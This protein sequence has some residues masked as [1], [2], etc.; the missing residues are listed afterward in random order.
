M[1]PPPALSGSAGERAAALLEKLEIFGIRPGLERTDQLLELLARPERAQPVVLVGG[2]NGKGSTATLL[3]AMVSA[4]GYRT[5]L[6]TSPHLESLNERIAI[7]G[8]KI[9][10]QELAEDLEHILALA[11]HHRLDPPTHFEILTLAA[12]LHF[13]RRQVDLAIMEVGLGGRLDATNASRPQLSILTSI[14]FDHEQYLGTSLEAIA[15]E[16]AA[17]FRPGRP[18]LAHGGDDRRRDLLRRLAQ[19]HQAELRLVEEQVEIEAH[20]APHELPQRLSARTGRGRYR[21][22]LPLAG[23][24]QRIHLALA[25]AAAEELAADGFA[26]LDAAAVEGGARSSRWPGRLERVELPGGRQVLL[27]AAHNAA[28]AAALARYLHHLGGKNSLVFGAL[29][30]KRIDEM[31]DQLA[32]CATEIILTRPSN[33]RAADPHRWRRTLGAKVRLEEEPRR[34]LAEALERTDGRIVICG[35]IY[36]VGELRQE[37]RALF[38]VPPP[39]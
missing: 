38:G 30:D 4:A 24:H 28:G 12:W 29:A 8:R 34:A 15:G 9:S 37:L 6:Y 25:V 27:D 36:L 7:D 19:Q 31:L 39:P 20:G 32:P 26:R 21:V 22:S 13:R 14:D 2:T 35:S 18:A 11:A 17:I 16:K 33:P 23:E 5:G 3:A 1:S 10:D